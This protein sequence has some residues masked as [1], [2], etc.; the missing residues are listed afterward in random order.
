MSII[1]DFKNLPVTPRMPI[2]FLGHG[3]PMNAIED[4]IF[5]EGFRNV[6]KKIPKPTAILCISAHWQTRGS[7]V[8]AMEMPETIHDFGG[9]PPELFAVQY[10]A[11]GSPILAH[12]ISEKLSGIPVLETHDWGLDHGT[13]SVIRHLYPDADIPV[14]QLSLDRNKDFAAHYRIAA[15]LQFL[16][17]RGVLIVGSG[18]LVHNLRMLDWRRLEEPGFA[19]D[20]ALEAQQTMRTKLLDGDNLGL[21]NI[22]T[23]GT[24]FEYSIPTPEH[25]WPLLYILGL[26]NKN[27]NVEIF[28]DLAVGGAITMTSVLFS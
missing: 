18:N 20:W 5:V 13:W 11:P 16:R 15:E 21:V 1:Q 17:E 6:A 8:T 14:L 9:F 2:L 24:A 22:R 25:Y 27:E 7:F 28:N 4:N 10:P 26:K 19:F 23:L 12:E 3:S